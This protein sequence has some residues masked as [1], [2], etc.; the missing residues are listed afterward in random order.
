MEQLL[1]FYE[2]NVPAT[3]PIM[4]KALQETQHFWFGLLLFY[5]HGI[6]T[7]YQTNNVKALKEWLCC[8]GIYC[9]IILLL[10]LTVV[11]KP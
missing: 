6:S 8:S 5:R 11:P 2:L 10:Q 4:S 9:V 1:D 7:P 3:Q